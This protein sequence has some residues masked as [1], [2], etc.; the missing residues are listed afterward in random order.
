MKQL[1]LFL[2]ISI[3]TF[4]SAQKFLEVDTKIKTYPKLIT[5]SKLADK[6][7]TDFNSDEE[8]VRAVFSWLSFNIRY[9][10]DEFY[11]PK[12]KRIH[13]RYK[14]E[15][16]K[17]AKIRA[18]KD[19]IVKKTLSSR[20]AV[21][22]GYAQTFGKVCTLLNIENQVVKGY[23]RNSSYD[24]G[25]VT[26]T[27]NHA[28]NAVKLN[29]KWIYIDATWAA[30]AVTNG[31]WQHYFNDYFFNIPKQKYFYTHFP[32][33]K[34]W[35]LRVKRMSLNTYFKQPIYTPFFLKKD[36]KLIK[37]NSG[38]LYKKEDGSVS[39]TLKNIRKNQS[40]LCGFRGFK[41]AKKP[42]TSFNKNMVIINIIPPKNSKEIYLIIDNDVVLEFLLK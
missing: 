20:S 36:Y 24:I 8:K 14:D 12:Q 10:L 27:T 18:I 28:W 7:S 23:V 37:P 11:N 6:I 40:I 42:R 35:Q 9:N 15:A 30:G 22:E 5:A 3:P 1:F 38:I 13:F 29:N 21:C 17:Q 31:K 33:D 41:Y 2:F 25:R 34:L 26:K 4:L 32:E 39:L 16:D 19:N